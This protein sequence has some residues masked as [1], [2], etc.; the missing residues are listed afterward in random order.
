MG[1]RGWCTRDHQINN[2]VSFLHLEVW[3]L[4]PDPKPRTRQTPRNV[5]TKVHELDINAAGTVTPANAILTI[6]YMDI[7]Y[8]PHPT[9]NQPTSYVKR[10]TFLQLLPFFCADSL[11][12]NPSSSS[13]EPL[14][15][16][17]LARLKGGYRSGAYGKEFGQGR[18]DDLGYNEFSLFQNRKKLARGDCVIGTFN[19]V[20]PAIVGNGFVWNVGT[21]PTETTQKGA[22]TREF[23]QNSSSTV[24]N[25]VAWC[26]T[27]SHAA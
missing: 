25:Y 15:E 22:S 4:Q 6:L 19:P 13:Q 14:Y 8:N 9:G 3:T 18:K 20:T 26:Q 11:R 17:R 2:P 10:R 23:F 7:F 24:Q 27:R 5:P 12:H 16:V 1:K 21:G